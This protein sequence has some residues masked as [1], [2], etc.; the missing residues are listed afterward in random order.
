MRP[1]EGCSAPSTR[2]NSVDLPQPV[3][4]SRQQN[5]PSSIRKSIAWSI[6]LGGDP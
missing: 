6:D 4:P 1:L 5:S 2:R 3:C